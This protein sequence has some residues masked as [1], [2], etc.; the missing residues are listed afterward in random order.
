M[1]SP[2]ASGRKSKRRTSWAFSV[3]LVVQVVGLGHAGLLGT[4]PQ[5][6]AAVG[7]QEGNHAFTSPVTPTAAVERAPPMKLI[8]STGG[9]ESRKPCRP[10]GRGPA[11]T[12]FV[13]LFA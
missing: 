4:N 2:P 1:A 7:A 10:L 5:L 8:I 9:H 6:I 3:P 11:E 13:H 12:G